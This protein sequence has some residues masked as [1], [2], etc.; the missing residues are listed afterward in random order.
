M[1]LLDIP[2]EGCNNL[3]GEHFRTIDKAVAH[4]GIWIQPV[5]SAGNRGKE[6]KRRLERD[7]KGI[8]VQEIY[9]Y[10]V[11]KF[12]AYLKDKKL[13]QRLRA[14]KLDILLDDTFRGFRPPKYKR[15]RK[16]DRRLENMEYLYSLLRESSIGLNFQTPLRHPDASSNLGELGDEYDACLGA[17]VGIFF[18]NKSS[19][20]CIVGNSNSGNIL[21][22]A[23]QWLQTQLSNKVEVQVSKGS[24]RGASFPLINPPP[25]CQREGDTGGR[26]QQKDGV[27]QP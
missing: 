22:L 18:A 9:P 11:Y 14:N 26:S 8:I 12:L 23:D 19:Y 10:A 27:E 7:N 13:L 3:D 25:P 4:Q 16:K 6:L 2:I 1:V 5:S 24:P 17:I 15:E 21:L 20:A